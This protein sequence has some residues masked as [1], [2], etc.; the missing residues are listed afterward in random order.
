MIKRGGVSVSSWGEPGSQS[1]FP[2][3][4][5]PEDTDFRASPMPIGTHGLLGVLEP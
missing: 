3:L 4:K 5:V 1:F 2:S